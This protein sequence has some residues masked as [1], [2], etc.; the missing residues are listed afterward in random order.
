MKKAF[1]I[2]VLIGIPG[3]SYAAASVPTGACYEV[4]AAHI[5][6]ERPILLNRCTGQTWLLVR[7]SVLDAA[8]KE[9]TYIFTWDQISVTQNGNSFP[10]TK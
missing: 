10:N 9:S 3:T 6:Q 5:D 2:A 8:G 4:I 7:H 1:C